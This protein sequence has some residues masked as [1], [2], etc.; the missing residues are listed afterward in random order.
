MAARRDRGA[1]ADRQ[2]RAIR[3]AI[4]AEILTARRGLGVSQAVAGRSVGMSHAQVGRIERGV[5]EYVTVDQLARACEA[6]GLKLVVRAY[7]GG[8]AVRD[9]G[10]L[11][12]LARF[13]ARIPPSIQVRTEV[14]LPI[15]RDK[16]A[17]DLVLGAGADRVAVEAETRLQDLQALER[18]IA[19][20]QRDGRIDRVIL[21]VG[22]TA[23]NRRILAEQRET[24]R[25]RFPGEGRH[26]L[27]AL[28][29]GTLPVASGVLVL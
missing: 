17:W 29:T 24:L 1:E 25:A 11:S 23:P 15:S 13:R 21:L 5:L 12:L 6:V 19:L 28:R 9:A 26:V 4:G 27:S 7:P 3:A 20:K 16:R 22:D 8:D 14:P 10:H 18:R 2:S